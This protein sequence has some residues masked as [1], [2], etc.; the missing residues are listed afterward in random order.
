MFRREYKGR[1]GRPECKSPP[2]RN[3]D[4]WI[5]DARSASTIGNGVAVKKSTIA[6]GGLGLFATRPFLQGDIVTGYAGREL[7]RAEA[8]RMRRADPAK[9]SHIRKT[10]DQRY[11]IDGIRRPQ[12]GRGGGSFTN[13]SDEPNCRFQNIGAKVYLVART[14]IHKGEEMFINYGRDYIWT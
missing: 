2:R 7:T 14:N 1:Y 8:D 13:H 11:V 10:G 6:G 12:D 5:R 3:E 4:A 9:A